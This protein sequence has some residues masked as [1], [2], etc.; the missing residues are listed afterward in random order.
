MS[1]VK[2]IQWN[3]NAYESLVL[4]SKTK[5]IVKVSQPHGLPN[6][7]A[8]DGGDP[9]RLTILQALVESHKY[10]AAESIDDVI[11][12]KGKGGSLVSVASKPRSWRCMTDAGTP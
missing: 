11:Q 3:E 4:E 12:G 2:E 7:G 5:D 9:K 10:H 8:R 1:G 6:A